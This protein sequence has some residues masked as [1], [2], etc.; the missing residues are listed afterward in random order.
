MQKKIVIFHKKL[1]KFLIWVSS[2]IDKLDLRDL[3]G[4]YRV[5][6]GYTK[7]VG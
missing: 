6:Y 2:R 7:I 4:G 5:A 1:D 3:D